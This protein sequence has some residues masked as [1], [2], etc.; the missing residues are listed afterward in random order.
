MGSM[1][2][3]CGLDCGACEGY[4]AT[5]A[6]DAAAKEKVAAK[7]RVEFGN[8]KVDAKYVTCDGCRTEDGVLGG[9]CAECEQRL[10]A[11]GRGL[12][13]CA[14]CPDYGCE[15]LNKLHE[16]IPEAK[17]RLDQIHSGLQS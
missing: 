13:N 7:W 6:N 4:L 17:V 1:I 16:F 12:P 3:V 11:I 5:Q 14:Y 2:G 9:H 10:C 15:K 8:P